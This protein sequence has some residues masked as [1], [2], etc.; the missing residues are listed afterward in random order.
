[1]PEEGEGW[2]QRR[3]HG[4]LKFGFFL[5]EKVGDGAGEGEIDMEEEEGEAGNAGK[6][7]EGWQGRRWRG[8]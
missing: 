1:M 5:R 6:V 8:R 3:G 4:Q 7:E 2:W